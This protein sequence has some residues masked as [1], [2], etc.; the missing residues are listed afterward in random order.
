LSEKKEVSAVRVCK[1]S[2]CDAFWWAPNS[3]GRQIVE[4]C[5]SSGCIDSLNGGTKINSDNILA[6]NTF[7]TAWCGLDA[8]NNPRH[9]LL[10]T[11]SLRGKTLWYVCVNG[12]NNYDEQLP[13]GYISGIQEVRYGEEKFNYVCKGTGWEPKYGSQNK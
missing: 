13:L 11:E 9:C 2:N 3:S 7:N 6:E 8:N 5:S 12:I 1:D 4:C 10:C